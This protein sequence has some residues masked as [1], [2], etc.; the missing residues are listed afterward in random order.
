MGNL[1]VHE[2]LYV[3]MLMQVLVYHDL[4]GKLQHSHHAKANV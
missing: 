1:F 3:F 4:L 2:A